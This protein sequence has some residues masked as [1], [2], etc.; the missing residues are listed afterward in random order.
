MIATGFWGVKARKSQRY[1]DFAETVPNR[2]A[3]VFLWKET[4]RIS[5]R[6]L[7]SARIPAFARQIRKAKVDSGGSLPFKRIEKSTR[8][9]FL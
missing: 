9:S 7:N 2:A 1:R 3:T 8:L 4:V 5:L 6:V